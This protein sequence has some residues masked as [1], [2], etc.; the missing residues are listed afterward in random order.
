MNERVGVR[1]LRDAQQD[2]EA[3]LDRVQR[4]LGLG[5]LRQRKHQS[6]QP[7]SLYKITH[8][9]DDGTVL[10]EGY[11]KIARR[12]RRRRRRTRLCGRYGR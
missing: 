3:Q 11:Q 10:E 7:R 6:I 5:V 8:L 2:E 4:R 1:V 12:H 9:H